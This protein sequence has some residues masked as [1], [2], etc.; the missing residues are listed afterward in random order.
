M[1]EEAKS[2]QELSVATAPL[3]SATIFTAKEILT[4]DPA[5]PSA[6][7]VAV[8]GGRILA[9]GSLDELKKAAGD[10]HTSW[11]TRLRTRSSFRASSASTITPSS[12]D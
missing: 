3:P 2:L 8:V 7:A 10:H 12:P 6:E 5:N 11:T 1:A 9:V 4:L